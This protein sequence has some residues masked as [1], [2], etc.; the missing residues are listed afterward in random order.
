ML[1]QSGR[2]HLAQLRAAVAN[3][4]LRAVNL[5]TPGFGRLIGGILLVFPGFITDIVGALLLVPFVRQ[6]A[7]ESVAEARK[8]RQARR[9]PSVIDLAPGEWTQISERKVDHGRGRDRRSNQG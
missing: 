9:D 5:N 4:G 2:A 6:R 1:R 8:E 3:G 7:G